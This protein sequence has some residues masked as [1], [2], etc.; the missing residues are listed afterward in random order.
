VKPC[1]DP[2]FRLGILGGGQLG[3]M[4][5]QAASDW[6]LHTAVLDPDPAAPAR[7]VCSRFQQ[8]D[9][10]KTD[11]VLRFAEDLDLL[12]VEIESVDIA[13]L[14]QLAARGLTVR[15]APDALALIQ[16][17]GRQKE[18]LVRHGLPTSRFECL[19][20][21]DEVRTAVADGRRSMPFVQKLRRMGYDGRGVLCVSD[22]A[23]LDRLL[24]GPCLVEDYVNVRKE[25]AVIAA[26]RASGEVQV[27]PAVEMVFHPTANLVEL[28]RSPADLPPAIADQARELAIQTIEAFGL[29]GLLAVEMFLDT[30]DRLWINEVAPRPHNS[31]HHTLANSAT[32]QYE[33]HLRAILDLPLG[34]TDALAHAAMVNLLGAEGHRGK[35]RYQGMEDCLRVP[36]CTLHIYGKPETRPFRKMGH[37]TVVGQDPESVLA[38]AQYVRNTLKVIT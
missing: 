16:D 35:P 15:P 31:G 12:T 2:D 27:F 19:A 22:R 18:F 14:E 33:Q 34:A 11:D 3:K 32:S 24:D 4:L 26:R 37:A 20:G 17:K 25:I 5:C 7:P 8:G 30:Q 6:H 21:R 38:A 13:A 10:R 9:F 36:G 23:D 29:S 1:F 28:L